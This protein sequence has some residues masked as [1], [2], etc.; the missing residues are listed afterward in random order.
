MV[1][2]RGVRVVLLVTLLACSKP[3]SKQAEHGSAAGSAREPAAAPAA[4]PAA[5]R[6]PARQQKPADEEIAEE[7]VREIPDPHDRELHG[8]DAVKLRSDGLWQV[9][10][11]VMEFI[12]DVPLEDTLRARI[13]AALRAVPGVV[14]L[15]EED[16]EVWSVRGTPT[17][18]ALVDA[19]A[20]VVDELATQ[21][22]DEINRQLAK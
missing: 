5:N 19:V 20:P 14:D 16:R 22:R 15:R 1:Y 2:E 3:A 10:V 8:V 7:W 18:S 9:S 12:R 13:P 4:P 17:G 11:Y 6:F 21:S